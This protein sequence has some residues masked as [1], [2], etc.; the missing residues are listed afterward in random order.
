M[1]RCSSCGIEHEEANFYK[2]KYRNDGYD[3]RC[4]PCRLEQKRR[5]REENPKQGIEYNYR[6]RQENRE[7]VAEWSRRY[8]QENKEKEAERS[9]RYRENNKEK[10]AERIKRWG[11]ANKGRTTERIKRY[12][13]TPKGKATKQRV[14]FKRRSAM[15]AIECTLTALQWEYVIDGLCDGRCAYCNVEFSPTVTPTRDHII[16]VNNGGPHTMANVTASCLSCNSSK[17]TKTLAEWG[18]TPL[19]SDPRLR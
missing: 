6:Y 8:S 2:D 3:H 12:R 9:R 1:K 11:Q 13:Q 7:K 10:V 4:K 5:Y 17:G 18:R 19:G 16:P 15:A 14:I